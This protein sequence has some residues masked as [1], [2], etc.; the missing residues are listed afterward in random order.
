MF[1]T[2]AMSMDFCGAQDGLLMA[3]LV[4][5]FKHRR[6]I[7]ALVKFYWEFLHRNCCGRSHKPKGKK[8]TTHFAVRKRYRR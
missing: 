3:S 8:T 7:L 6:S 5:V 4:F 1:A 2:I